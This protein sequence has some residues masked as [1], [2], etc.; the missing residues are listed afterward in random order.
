MRVNYPALGTTATKRP[1][2]AEGATLT[3]PS[4]VTYRRINGHWVI[5]GKA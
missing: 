1:M 4:G 3:H 5:E 2:Y